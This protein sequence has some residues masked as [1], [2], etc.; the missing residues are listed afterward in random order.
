MYAYDF[1][2]D[3]IYYNIT[4]SS[5]AVVTYGNIDYS[6]EVIIPSTVNYNGDVYSVT[7]IGMWAFSGCSSLTNVI[8]GENSQLTSIGNSAFKDC[9]SLASIEIPNS[10]TSIEQSAFYG[11]TSLANVIFEEKSQLASIGGYAFGGCS[12][13]TSIKI[14]NSVTFIDFSYGSPFYGC[15]SLTN[16][17]FGENSQLT[18]IGHSAFRDCTSLASIEIPNSVTSIGHSAFSGCSSLSSIEIPNSITIIEE[19]VF[20]SC[21]SLSSITIGYSVENIGE[22]AFSGCSSLSSIYMTGIPP[23]VGD[24]NFTYAQYMNT[25]L[26][27]PEGLIAKYQSAEVWENFVNIKEYDSTGME[28]INMDNISIEVTSNGISLSD[29]EGKPIAIYSINGILVKKIDNYTGEEIALNK[30]VYIVCVG[31]KAMK[32]I[33]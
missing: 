32:I 20:E 22:F 9:T 1:E 7:S 27:V 2:V 8:F 21:S 19:S 5:T 16:V 23:K 15:S 6:G 31:D 11:C 28:D 25:T 10:V 18:S 26:Y 13:L 30:G 33:L 3:G 4:S 24:N 29:S 14:P 12:S 17:I